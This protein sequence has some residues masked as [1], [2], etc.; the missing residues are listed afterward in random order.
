MKI[1]NILVNKYH[2][3]SICNQHNELENGQTLV[4]AGVK[5]KFL[6]DYFKKI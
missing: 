4:C 2:S 1:L 5:A 6:A 3:H